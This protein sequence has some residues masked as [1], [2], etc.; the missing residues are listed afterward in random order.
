MTAYVQEF[1][2]YATE[3]SLLKKAAELAAAAKVRQMVAYPPRQEGAAPRGINEIVCSCI[4]SILALRLILL[5]WMQADGTELDTNGFFWAGYDP[6][7]RVTGRHNEVS[8]ACLHF[9]V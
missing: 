4:V 2:G 8:Y 1:G 7:Y 9:A 3:Q 6:P 5:C